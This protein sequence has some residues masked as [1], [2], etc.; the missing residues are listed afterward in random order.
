M[1]TIKPRVSKY[2]KPNQGINTDQI[3]NKP[4]VVRVAFT[5]AISDWAFNISPKL[6][7]ILSKIILYS[8]CKNEKLDF[9]IHH[10]Y[11]FNF[12]LSSKNIKLRISEKINFRIILQALFNF[13][14]IENITS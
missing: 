8:S 10:K 3:I 2:G 1:N 5:K 11:F 13:S 6:L 4:I 7:I 9:F 12:F 14:N